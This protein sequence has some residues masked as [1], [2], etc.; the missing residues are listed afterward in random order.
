MKK[1]LLSLFALFITTMAFAYDAE[2]DGIY[3]NFNSGNKTAEVTDRWFY[4]GSY[5]GDIIIPEKVSYNGVEYSV[6]SI[7]EEAFLDCTGLTSVEI[8]N[9]IVLLRLVMLHF[10]FVHPSLPSI[11]QM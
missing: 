1:T 2:I 9:S 7:G 6:T 11:Y 4:A 3:Y 8:P 10:L 5:S